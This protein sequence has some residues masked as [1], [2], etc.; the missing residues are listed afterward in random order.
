MSS[1]VRL[2]PALAVA[3]AFI[4][5]AATPGTT[6]SPTC[7]RSAAK[8][9]IAASKLPKRV[10]IDASG[11]YG[12]GVNRLLCRE[13]TRDKQE[14]MVASIYSGG[15]AGDHAWIVFA[16]TQR[17]WKLLFRRLDLY[18]VGLRAASNGIVETLPLYKRDDPNCCPTG[19]FDHKLFRRRHGRFALARAWHT[20]K[21]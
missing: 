9:A 4:A 6:S 12:A 11:R 14:D 17:G 2:A 3:A 8:R 13:L 1:L 10:K 7:S 5:S 16:S 20:A 19:G 18:K 15:T 21:P